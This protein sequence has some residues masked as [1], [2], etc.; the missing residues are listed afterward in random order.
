MHHGRQI[1]AIYYAQTAW[2]F[3]KPDSLYLNFHAN[4]SSSWDLR[5]VVK[6]DTLFGE[7]E[8]YSDAMPPSPIIIPLRATRTLCK[9]PPRR[10]P[11]ER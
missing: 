10:P 5:L 8:H 2:R 7:A 4:M 9:R 6:A 1:G 3:T 11:N